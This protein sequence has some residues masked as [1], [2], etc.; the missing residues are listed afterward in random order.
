M[1]FVFTE[2]NHTEWEATHSFKR[3]RWRS[4]YVQEVWQLKDHTLEKETQNRNKNRGENRKKGYIHEGLK[5]MLRR[6]KYVAA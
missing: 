2:R 5:A 1:S 6:Q 3:E 4:L